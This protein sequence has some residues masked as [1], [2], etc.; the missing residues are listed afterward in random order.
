MEELN[1]AKDIETRKVQK[2]GSSSLFITLPKKWINKWNVKPG[3]KILIE[4]SSDGSLK[5][6]AEKVKME[7]T[8]RTIKIDVDSLKQPL[9]S[10][11]PCLYSLG[12]DE[13]IL[14]SRKAIQ[15]KDV[16]DLVQVTKQMVGI[17]VT[18]VSETRIKVE[19]L[20]DT[21]KVGIESL[22]RRMLNT[23]AK[24]I[25]DTIALLSGENLKEN[26]VNHED[27]RRLYYM[28]MRRIMGSKYETTKNMTKNSLIV[29][30]TTTLL[31]VGS[32]TEKLIETVK[33]SKLDERESKVIVETLRKVNDLLDEVVMTVLFPSTKRVLNGLN[34]VKESRAILSQLDNSTV[35]DYAKQIVGLLETALENSSCTLFLEDMPWIE[36]NLI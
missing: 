22:L 30:N 20:L 6:I 34:L 16:E 2:L 8:H 12:Y 13:I 11:V 17:E 9:P 32:V 7:N 10:I 15:S 25:D 24:R 5:L 27:L 26:S 33:S 21:E 31:N 14:E 3:D 18:E 36:R 4:V 28:L 23:V 29:I 19:C 35:V 1:N